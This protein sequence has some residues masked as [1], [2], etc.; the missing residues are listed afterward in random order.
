MSLRKTFCGGWSRVTADTII[1]ETTTLVSQICAQAQTLPEDSLI[2]LARYIEFLR[3]K[4]LQAHTVQEQLARDY[5]ELAAHYDELATESA[6][7]ASPNTTAALWPRCHSER[8]LR[9]RSGQ[10]TGA[11]NLDCI[12]GSAVHGQDALSPSL[13]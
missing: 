11:K 7:L 4:A 9:L 13:P 6:I 3:Y 1:V 2:E 5:D 12:Q 8:P 10:A